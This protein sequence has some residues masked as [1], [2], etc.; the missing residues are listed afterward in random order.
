MM[1][2]DITQR[3]NRIPWPPILAV[4]AVLAAWILEAV[5]PTGEILD[6]AGRWA[7]V[8]GILVAATGL[9]FDL[10]AMLTLHRARTNILPHRAAGHLVTNG[11]FALS[12]NPIY[13]GNT[14]LLLGL[15]LALHSPWLLVTALVAAVLV[16]QLAIKREE[17]HLAARFGTLFAQYRQRV[18]RWF[19]FPRRR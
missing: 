18:P 1:N 9:G 15:A 12:R 5:W 6:G 16:N 10:A 4:G 3:P 17:R 11:V 14:L 2:D 8:T 7:R 19:G 13:L